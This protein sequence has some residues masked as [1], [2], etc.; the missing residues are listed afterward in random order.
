MANKKITA[1]PALGATP[2][3][4]D[5]LPI[6]DVSGTATTKKVTVANLVAAAPQGDLV[7]SNNLSDVANAGTSRTNLGLG[8]AATAASTDFSPAFFTTV[9]ESTTARTL[10]D[11]D[12]GKIIVCSNSAT[13]TVTIPTGLTAGFSC[14]IV[15]SG[16]GTVQVEGGA[17][18][19]G[20]GSK[21]ATA[22]QYA[23]LNVIPIGTNIYVLE[24]DGQTP[25]FVNTYSVNFDKTDDFCGVSSDPS[26]DVYS[27]SLWFKAST[28]I[29]SS[30]QG[31]LVGGVTSVYGGIRIGMGANRILEYNDGTQYIAGGNIST[32]DTNWHNVI[33][34]YVNSGYT[35]TTGTASNNGKGYK[36]FL[37]GSRVDTAL[38][39]TSHNFA[40]ATSTAKLK[41]AR[42]G[43][44][45]L[46]FFGGL[47]DEFA[48]FGSSLSDSDVSAIYNS[49]VP[50]DLTAFNSTLWW[51]MG[52]NDS[53]TGTTI[54]DQGTGGNNGTLTNG[55]TFST[56]VPS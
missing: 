15:Q 48:I 40:L 11:S 17:T 6:V 13:V 50:T 37:D 10:S 5:V 55:P 27:M 44:R 52:D 33:M 21:T 24:G 38:G 30:Y 32:I 29:N 28:T 41:L 18:I 16:T 51:R 3:T 42:E 39:S 36:L 9:A 12:N 23:A 19:Y 4:D 25:P 53:G 54:T 2:A 43:E 26:L 46:Y 45:A 56:T 31:T 35:T 49:G 20:L 8:T 1:L 7:A 22:G 14:T 34:V 47:I